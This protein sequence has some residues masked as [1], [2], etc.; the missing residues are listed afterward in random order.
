LNRA[1]F[2]LLELFGWLVGVPNSLKERNWADNRVIVGA[3][4]G[5]KGC[6]V[7]N[8]SKKMEKEKKKEKTNFVEK[9][10]WEMGG[11]V[12]LKTR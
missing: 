8:L 1:V 4:D 10:S 2:H 5:V 7:S 9:D 3:G 12:H 6:W 11:I